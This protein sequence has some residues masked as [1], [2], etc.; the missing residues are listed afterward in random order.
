MYYTTAIYNS[1]ASADMWENQ[2]VCV[3]H[4]NVITLK[5]DTKDTKG[6]FNL[7]NQKLTENAMAKR[8]TTKRQNTET[9]HNIG[10]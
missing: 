1:N 9:K 4:F 2:Y 7:I 3:T 6:I 10:N 8:K 5:I